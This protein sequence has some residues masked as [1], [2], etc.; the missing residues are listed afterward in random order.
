MDG[1]RKNLLV[2]LS[3]AVLLLTI[4]SKSSAEEETGLDLSGRWVSLQYGSLIFTQE[5][6]SFTAVWTGTK[7]EGTI[8]GR[9]ASFR[10]W[11]GASFEKA[12]DDSRGYGTLTFSDD[13]NILS[14][15]WASQSKSDPESG[16]FTAIRVASISGQTTQDAAPALEEPSDGPAAV[17]EPA[18]PDAA[19]AAGASSQQTAAGSQASAA[20]TPSAAEPSDGPDLLPDNVPPEYVGPIAEAISDLEEYV[21]KIF[22]IFDEGSGDESDAIPHPPEDIRLQEDLPPEYA[23]PVAEAILDLEELVL[24]IF[25]IFDDE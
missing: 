20:G 5:G 15:S 1:W 12:K 7:A 25:G 9:Q 6:N 2:F 24:K 22:S 8:S 19:P 23:G 10:F 4:A 11:A 3:V 13:G 17:T 16:S 21:L 18:P 14:G